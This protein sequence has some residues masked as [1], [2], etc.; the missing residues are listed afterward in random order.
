MKSVI[1]MSAVLCSSICILR[2][3]TVILTP[4]TAVRTAGPAQAAPPATAVQPASIARPA[5]PA[6][7]AQPAKG[8]MPFMITYWCGPSKAETNLERYKELADCGFN[9]AFPAID[10]L[11]E[12]ASK[13]QELHNLKV[14]DLCQKV[15][16]KALIWDGSITN[17][18]T[19]STAPKPEESPK[20]EKTLDGLISKYSRNPAFLGFVLGD[21]GNS[22]EGNLRLGVVNQYLAKKDPKHLAYFNLLPSY[23]YGFLHGQ[24]YEKFIVDYIR[25]AKPPYVSWDHYRQMF[26][27]GDESLYWSNLEIVRKH[28]LAAKIPYIQIIVSIKHMGYREC[29][30]ADLRWQVWTSLAY[31]SRGITYFT[32]CHVPGMAWGDAPALLT[33]DGRR[34]AKWG[35]VQ[36]INHRIAKLGPTLVKL[37]STGVYCTDPL[38]PGTQGLSADAPVAK[39]EG[40][41]MAIGCFKDPM[42]K[43]YMMV[44]NRSL[45]GQINAKLTM[46][47]KVSSTAEVSQ[48]TGKLLPPAMLKNK[49]L[50][51][52]LEAGEG[53]LFALSIR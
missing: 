11:W 42:G 39:A 18:G 4:A 30:E 26:E 19:W 6:T 14:L 43:V 29:S 12:P 2:A 15:G 40:G 51:V 24:D 21:E 25:D 31:G 8:E 45:G 10:N 48:E 53:R 36:K 22:A 44:V 49:I 17:V 7:T 23:A 34:D 9:V 20:I 47:P 37:T 52:P 35:Y 27:G 41:P 3:E 38:P 13:T 33:K 1:L 16:M 32:Y 50:D 46:Q 28:C 5:Q